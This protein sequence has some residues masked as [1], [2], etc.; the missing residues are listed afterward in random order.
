MKTRLGDNGDG[1]K[2]LMFWCPGCKESHAARVRGPGGSRPSWEWNGS[3]DSPTL[4]PSLLVTSGHHVAGHD[5]GDCWCTYNAE[6]PGEPAPFRCQVC[7]S[8]VRDGRIQFLGDCTHELA[9][10]TVDIP[11]WPRSHS[12]PLEVA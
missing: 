3:R 2:T 10:Q 6:N 9:G 12:E 4:S 5:G 11:E 8:F 7:H 1:S